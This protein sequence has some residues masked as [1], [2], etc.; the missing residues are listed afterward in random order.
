MSTLFRS[1]PIWSGHPRWLFSCCSASACPTYTLLTWLTFLHTCPWPQLVIVLTFR[2][3]HLHHDSLSK[4]WWE[5]CPSAS[6][7]G[8]QWANLTPIPPINGNFPLPLGVKTASMSCPP[9]ATLSGAL[10]QDLASDVYDPPC[11]K[12]LMSLSLTQGSFF[13]LEDGQVQVLQACGVQPNNVTYYTTI[14]SQPSCKDCISVYCNMYRLGLC[15]IGDTDQWCGSQH[16]G[17]SELLTE[18]EI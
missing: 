9:S 5:A 7:P 11:I 3:E 13:S 16:P 15:W 14:L 8:N 18:G 6:F 1:M 17:I 2:S 4:G 10:F 12:P